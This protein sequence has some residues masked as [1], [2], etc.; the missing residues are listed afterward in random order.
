M[1]GYHTSSSSQY[2]SILVP[3]GRAFGEAVGPFGVDTGVAGLSESG[4][5]VLVRVDAGVEVVCTY[6]L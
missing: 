3:G 5:P 4:V 6:C 2:T 1:H